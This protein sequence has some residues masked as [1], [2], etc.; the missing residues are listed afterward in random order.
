MSTSVVRVAS[1]VAMVLGFAVS[2]CGAVDDGGVEIEGEE[3]VDAVTDELSVG[4]TTVGTGIQER[5]CTMKKVCDFECSDPVGDDDTYHCKLVC[6][7]VCTF[8]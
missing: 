7:T 5:N 4:S 1:T 2:G 3:A 8:I 6:K